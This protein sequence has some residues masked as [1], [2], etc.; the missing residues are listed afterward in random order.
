MNRLHFKKSI[1]EA[2]V[3]GVVPEGHLRTQA[4][5]YEDM[6]GWLAQLEAGEIRVVNRPKVTI[7]VVSD[8]KSSVDRQ[9][10]YGDFSTINRN[11]NRSRSENTHDRLIANPEEWTHYHSVYRQ[12]RSEWVVTP[13]DEIIRWCRARSGYTIGDFGCGEAKV[14]EAVS[15]QHIVYSFDHIA[16]NDDVIACDM[17]SVPLDDDSLDVAV[18]SLSL[19]GSNFLDYLREAHRTLKLDGQL[20]VIEATSRFTDRPA[21][22]E[23]LRKLGF[24]I[25]SVEDKWKFT[26]IHMIKT[27]R[28]PVTD[29]SLRF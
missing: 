22:I 19:M 14:S 29:F 23:G 13:Y 6:L 10:R 4:Q 3:D 12:A 7:P 16:A 25:F 26:H 28:R 9:H 8:E 11:W 20:H 24:E 5:A 21:F 1:A 27:E 2:A 15:D 17:A 18:F